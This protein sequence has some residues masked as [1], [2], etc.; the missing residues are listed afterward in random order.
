MHELRG[1]ASDD[2]R[3]AFCTVAF[4]VKGTHCDKTLF[5]VQVRNSEGEA[6]I[7]VQWHK[8]AVRING[9]KDQQ[10]AI[11]FHTDK[12]TRHEHMNVAWSRIDDASMTAK[13]L[14]FF[15]LRLKE[16]SRD[17]ENEL[18]LNQVRNDRERP[19][20][21]RATRG[22]QAEAK[23]LGNDDRALRSMIR[24]AWER[25]ESGKGFVAVWKRFK[26]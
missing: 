4:L 23:R 19:E 17:Q 5:H 14:P 21:R 11:A 8:V 18:G 2:I 9:L 1:F 20:I 7:R 12:M 6:L 26:I 16:V 10:R 3:Q 13:P 25:A 22:E 15:K 24:D